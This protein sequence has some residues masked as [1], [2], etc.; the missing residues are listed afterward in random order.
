MA[1]FE[2]EE[3]RSRTEIYTGDSSLGKRALQR[4]LMKKQL[5]QMGTE[6]QEIMIYQSPPELGALWTEV[7]VMMQRMGAEQKI[8]II[9]QM[10]KQA[11]ID[12]RRAAR[13]KQMR[14]E[15]IV[16]VAILIVIMIMCG[17]FMWVAYDRQQKYPQYGDGIFP[18]T[19][20]QR[21][22]DEQPK[23]YIGR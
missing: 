5:Q 19:E 18:K 7:N 4:V 10:K 9:S 3:R 22:E 1:I 11:L 15:A 21:R 6:L 12:A 2:E 14:E 20:Q 16:G 13:F 23:I 17:V 8:L